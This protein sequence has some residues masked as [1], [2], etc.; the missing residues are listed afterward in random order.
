MLAI[1]AAK[2]AGEIFVSVVVNERLPGDTRF[3]EHQTSH[4]LFSHLSSLLD[5]SSVE[6]GR[7]RV[8]SFVLRLPRFNGGQCFF[9]AEVTGGEQGLHL[10][11]DKR[12][13]AAQL[14][15]GQGGVNFPLRGREG[16]AHPVVTVHAVHDP[17]FSPG[18]LLSR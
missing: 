18:D 14:A 17:L 13:V 9:L 15:L 1:V 5:F 8:R 7:F 10:F 12:Q 3:L 16:M 4:E 11:L 6:S 2:A